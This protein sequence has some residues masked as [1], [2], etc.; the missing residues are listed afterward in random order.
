M[1]TLKYNKIF[2]SMPNSLHKITKYDDNI[3][4]NR[5]PSF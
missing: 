1:E 5:G 3:G 4:S 2:I